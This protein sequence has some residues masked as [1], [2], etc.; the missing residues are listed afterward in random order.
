MG[1]ARDSCILYAA[2]YDRVMV[3]LLYSA[4]YECH[5]FPPP[6]PGPPTCVG[7][8]GWAQLDRVRRITKFRFQ[9][10]YSEEFEVAVRRTLR[11][12]WQVSNVAVVQN[13]GIMPE[14]DSQ[15]HRANSGCEQPSYV[16]GQRLH[17]PYI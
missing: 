3:I 8:S 12:E 1:C 17:Q 9:N 10:R 4:K 5:S 7:R 15:V 11:E 13:V 6:P 14:L 2:C 16:I